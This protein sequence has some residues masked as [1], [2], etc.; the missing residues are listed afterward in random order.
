MTESMARFY[1]CLTRA[2]HGK[3][4]TED[5]GLNLQNLCNGFALLRILSSPFK[6]QGFTIS[7][8]KQL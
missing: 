3:T 7:K 5:L 2:E 1:L 4:I 6:V 8:E